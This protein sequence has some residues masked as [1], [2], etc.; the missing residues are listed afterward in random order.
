[1]RPMNEQQLRKEV[2]RL[3]KTGKMPSLEKLC[4]VVG[5]T[6]EVRRQDSKSGWDAQEQSRENE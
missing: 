2:E 4:E 5:N 3:I 1:M 6:D